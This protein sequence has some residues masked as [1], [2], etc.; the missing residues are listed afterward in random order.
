MRAYLTLHQPAA[1]RDWYTRGLWREQTFY[2][3]MAGHVA[4][5]PDADAARDGSRTLSWRQ[6]QLWVDAVAEDLAVQGLTAGDRISF[7]MSNKLEAVVI[8]LACARNGY[9][10]NPSLHRTY[11]CAEVGGLLNQLSAR[12]FMTEPG[13]G[14]DRAEGKLEA[15]LAGVPSLRKVY[16]PST[17][18]QPRTTPLDTPAWSNPDSVR[19]LAF[20]SGTTGTPKCV[21]HSDNTLLANA[22]DMVRDWHH[23][24]H[25][26]LLTLSPVSHHIAWVAFAEWLVA[27]CELILDDPPRG[28]SKLDWVCETR[29]TYVMG[30]PTHAMDL[31]AEQARRSI[32][33]LG[34]VEVFYMAGS[35][36]PP[37]VA[38]AFVKQ[39]I[40]PQNVYG[41]TENSSHQY[42]HPTDDTE[43]IVTT[44]GRG[45]AAYEIK[46]FDLED[47]LHEVPHGTA[48]HIGGRGAALMLG[49]FGNQSAT[50][51][52]FN[53]DG[54]FLSGDMGVRDDRGNLK[55]V[56]RLK[57]LIIRGGHNIYPSNIEALAL[58]HPK[59]EKVAVFSVA[60]DR[61][62]ER[63]CIAVIG[64]IDAATLL[65]HLDSQGLSKFDMPEYFL[66][67]DAFPLT[68]SGKILK[69]VLVQ[70]AKDGTISPHPIRF[71]R[72]KDVA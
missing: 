46:V 55:I 48:G 57:D 14:A 35:P 70:Q 38:E 63:A 28:L 43:T 6:L 31:L 21:M 22:R 1:S 54:W 13:W 59:V 65:T 39:G 15:V 67:T 52:S 44:C 41:M 62:G 27:G 18:P 66:R 34:M 26:R 17:F 64:D 61:L 7:W 72:T 50:E 11:T 24:P 8:F 12:V 32:T 33:R 68:A 45:G 53:R 37:P 20:T 25:T 49:Y 36:I 3:L 10:C 2:A 19:Y 47:S 60:D 58:R 56:G 4:A 30:V 5:R 23:G 42:T 9:A 16:E 51:E 69:R 71:G 40:K 29:A